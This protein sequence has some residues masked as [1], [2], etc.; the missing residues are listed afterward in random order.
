MLVHEQANAPPTLPTDWHA[1]WEGPDRGLIAA[2]LR[3]LEKRTESPD[4]AA[5]ASAGELPVLAWRG[6]VEKPIKGGK[7]GTLLYLATWH[8]LRG[9][10]LALDT[11][12]EVR[13]RCARH[14][15]TVVYSAKIP[16]D[17]QDPTP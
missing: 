14:G 5:A 17:D 8:G 10:D 4:L 13:L 9:D 16:T 2:W 11:E 1:R 12:S 15:V 7:S 6:G 3:G